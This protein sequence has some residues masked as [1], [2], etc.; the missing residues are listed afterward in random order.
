[1]WLLFLFLFVGFGVGYLGA[2]RG[3]TETASASPL[4]PAE[5]RRQSLVSYGPLLLGLFGA[6]LVVSVVIELA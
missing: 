4:P 3:G 5:Q 2:R 1:V 6:G